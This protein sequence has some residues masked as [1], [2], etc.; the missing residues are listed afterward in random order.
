MKGLPAPLAF[1]EGWDVWGARLG[2]ELSACAIGNV[3]IR[4]VTGDHVSKEEDTQVGQRLLHFTR[5]GSG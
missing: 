3:F 1:R 4:Y 2:Q 5:R